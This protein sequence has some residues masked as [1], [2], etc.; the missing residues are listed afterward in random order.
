MA[1]QRKSRSDGSGFG[2]GRGSG[3]VLGG[4][5]IHSRPSFASRNL[6]RVGIISPLTILTPFFSEI[7]A[8]YPCGDWRF[9][10]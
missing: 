2:G 4:D 9:Q 5:G 7:R 10:S 3:R 1:E 8:H 6:I